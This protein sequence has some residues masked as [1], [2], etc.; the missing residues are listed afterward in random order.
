M[1]HMQLFDSGF[2]GA[3]ALWAY[4]CRVLGFYP[5][6]QVLDRLCLVTV[7]GYNPR[8]LHSLGATA[9]CSAAYAMTAMHAA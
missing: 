4:T 5:R 1:P 8:F 3:G 9:E 6:M 2:S 7:P